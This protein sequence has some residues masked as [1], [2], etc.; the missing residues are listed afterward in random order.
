MKVLCFGSLNIDYVYFVSHFVKGGETLSSIDFQKNPG[1]KGANQ[2]GALSKAGC[3]TYMAGKI[4]QDGKFL[5]DYLKSCNVDCSFVRVTDKT[6]GH[7]IIQLDDNRQ[8]AIVLYPGENKNIDISEID[9]V[10]AHFCSGDWIVLQNEINNIQ[11][12]INKAHEKGM[13]IC[14]NPAPFDSSIT[15]L[16]LELLNLLVVNEI[17]AAGLANIDSND[18][19]S[20][21]DILHS[22]YPYLE[23]IMTVGKKGAYY[24]KGNNRIHQPIIDGPVVDTTAAGDTFIGYYIASTIKG[25]DSSKALYYAS[26]ASGLTVSRQGAL[27]S[28]PLSD[29]VFSQEVL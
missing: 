26:K 22:K 18:F 1:G 13:F 16:P 7:A 12:I 8:N 2:A 24:Q 5:L 28:I 11:Y 17:E 15:S 27:S 10:L 6:T 19:E 23:I 29:E 25:F 14:L 3:E 9:D 4:G 21:L 20:I